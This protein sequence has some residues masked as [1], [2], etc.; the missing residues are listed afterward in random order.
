MSPHLCFIRVVLY[1]LNVFCDN[2]LTELENCYTNQT[3]LCKLSNM[4]KKGEGF[5]GKIDLSP[6]VQE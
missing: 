6:Q 1:D 2:A 4:E 5:A 3:M